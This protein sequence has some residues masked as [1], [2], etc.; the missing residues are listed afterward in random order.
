MIKKTNKKSVDKIGINTTHIMVM[1]EIK[2]DILL[3]IYIYI[4]TLDLKTFL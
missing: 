3:S 2:D 1:I 4:S